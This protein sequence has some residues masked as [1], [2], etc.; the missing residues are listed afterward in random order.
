MTST[1]TYDSINLTQADFHRVSDVIYKH[2]GINLHDGKQS[3]V[4]ARLARCLRLSRFDS[5]TEYLD[6]VLSKAGEQEFHTLVDSLST[7]LTSF[8]RETK[9]FAYLREHFLPH[10]IARK[11]KLAQPRVR[12]WSAG[13]SSGEEPYSLAVTLLEAFQ[14]RFKWDIK[15]LATDVSRQMLNVA[16]AGT[17]DQQR[18]SPLTA[19]QRQRFLL[20]HRIAGQQ[21]YQAAPALRS[22]AP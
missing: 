14:N 19:Q 3:L 5:L 2:C 21:L 6:Y 10:L 16:Q 15:I 13:C 22:A 7:N 4:R 12:F 17:Y 20:P 9:H 11:D 18:V 1:L 8:F